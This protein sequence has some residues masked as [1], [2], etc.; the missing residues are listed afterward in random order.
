MATTSTI[1]FACRG[2]KKRKISPA[3]P[4]RIP[5]SSTWLLH[6]LFSR[7]TT[8]QILFFLPQKIARRRL[9]MALM[10]CTAIAADFGSTVPRVATGGHWNTAE[11]PRQSMASVFCSLSAFTARDGVPTKERV[12]W[13]TGDPARQGSVTLRYWPPHVTRSGRDTRNTLRK[14]VLVAAA[15]RS[16]QD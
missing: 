10:C 13:G 15:F 16:K 8:K 9:A 7:K 1:L 12:G 11:E 2:K 3:P 5:P 4:C 14:A 6:F